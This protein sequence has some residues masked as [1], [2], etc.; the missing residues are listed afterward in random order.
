MS[1]QARCLCQA[2]LRSVATKLL[3]QRSCPGHWL[4][5]PSPARRAKIA[6]TDLGHRLRRCLRKVRHC[7]L[8]LRPRWNATSADF[9]RSHRLVVHLCPHRQCSTRIRRS[10]CTRLGQSRTAC[11]VRAWVIS[12]LPK[13][14][15]SLLARIQPTD[16]KI[17]TFLPIPCGL[18]ISDNLLIST[19]HQ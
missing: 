6:A 14:G 16:F 7:M 9:L 8:D 10:R 18:R 2:L 19:A 15:G 1:P 12:P 3:P 13:T 11:R 17:H 5:I 4:L